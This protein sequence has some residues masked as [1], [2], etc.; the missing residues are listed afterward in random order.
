MAG[1]DCGLAPNRGG[2]SSRRYFIKV[3][4]QGSGWVSM[5]GGNAMDNLG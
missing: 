5:L 3:S 4:L 1:L 2:V